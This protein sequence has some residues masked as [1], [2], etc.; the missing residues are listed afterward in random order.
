MVLFMFILYEGLPTVL[1]IIQ[2][3][4]SECYEKRRINLQLTGKNFAE[5]ELEFAFRIQTNINY[6]AES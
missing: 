2:R 5:V 3:S 1:I 6:H 4:K